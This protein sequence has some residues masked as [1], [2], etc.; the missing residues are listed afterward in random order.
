MQPRVVNGP[1]P[2]ICRSFLLDR[3]RL[4][5]RSIS[6]PEAARYRCQPSF[7]RI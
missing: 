4:Y 6:K 3:S 5:V 7:L 1:H 2:R